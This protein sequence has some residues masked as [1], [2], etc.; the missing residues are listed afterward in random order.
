MTALVCDPSREEE[1]HAD[2]HIILSLNAHREIC[3]VHKPGKVAISSSV[4][5]QAAKIAAGR[6][7]ELHNLLARALIELEEKVSNDREIKLEQLRRF[8]SQL[9]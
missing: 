1:I 6:V 7:Q 2:G 5:V 3:A 9:V 8:N 4:V